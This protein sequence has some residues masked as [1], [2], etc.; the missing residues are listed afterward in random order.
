MIPLLSVLCPSLV[1]VLMLETAVARGL[2]L[3]LLAEKWDQL[4][5]C[6]LAWVI[7][8]PLEIHFIYMS[9]SII[10]SVHPASNMSLF[11]L[12]LWWQDQTSHSYLLL[13]YH[14]LLHVFL[15]YH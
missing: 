2:H 5:S 9:G 1:A 10:K 15:I 6:V 13:F 3:C 4:Y 7:S 14:F 8:C 12:T 11:P